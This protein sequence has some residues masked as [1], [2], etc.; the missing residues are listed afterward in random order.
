MRKFLL[1][2]SAVAVLFCP[3]ALAQYEVCVGPNGGP[4]QVAGALSVSG[5]AN[6]TSPALTFNG[7]IVQDCPVNALGHNRPGSW[8]TDTLAFFNLFN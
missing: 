5:A 8:A 7:V 2:A 3:A 6:A 4:V 1:T